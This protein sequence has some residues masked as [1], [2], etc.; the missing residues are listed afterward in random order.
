ML[1]W[2]LRTP[3]LRGVFSSLR[4][5]ATHST[6]QP[7]V[8]SQLS[9]T[10]LLSTEV[11]AA[12]DKAVA[13]APVVLF[14]KGTPETPQ[15]GF[16]RTTIQILGL[17]GVDPSKFTAFNVLEDEELRSGI[18]QYSDWPTIPQLYVDKEFVGGCDILINMH[19]DG[20]LADL[21]AEKKVIVEEDD[22]EGEKADEAR[23]TTE[24]STG[25]RSKDAKG[26]SS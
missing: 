25:G 21:L 6:L 24:Q 20:S 19:K 1:Q 3:A 7:F 13:S 10:R 12:I 8:T 17:Q 4:P 26:E 15:C 22:V 5:G 23:Q 11:R 2:T 9:Q 18:K 14:M 16:S